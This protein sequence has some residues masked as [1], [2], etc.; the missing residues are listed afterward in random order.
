[1]K[2]LPSLQSHRFVLAFFIMILITGCNKGDVDAM[3]QNDNA[4]PPEDEIPIIPNTRVGIAIASAGVSGASL[5]VIGDASESQ[6]TRFADIW[7][8]TNNRLIQFEVDDLSVGGSDGFTGD[9]QVANPL[10]PRDILAQP[11]VVR[12]G[13]S[14]LLSVDWG[15]WEGDYFFKGIFNED[16]EQEYDNEIFPLTYVFTENSTSGSKITDLE[17]R[18]VSYTYEL[19]FGTVTYVN[20]TA[21]DTNEF[22]VQNEFI[23]GLNQTVIA[24]ALEIRFGSGTFGL[25][26]IVNFSL[27]TNFRGV[28]DIIRLQ[29][30]SETSRFSI[31][32]DPI[33]LEME[34]C[35]LCVYDLGFGF[36]GHA[37][38]ILVG[39]R[40]ESVIGSFEVSNELQSFYGTFILTRIES[41][42]GK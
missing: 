32:T 38:F 19:F 41:V 10:I 20:R 22:N 25:S 34:E 16:L 24:G 26:E 35:N 42:T 14:T 11:R 30:N 17:E 8:D 36:N 39:N 29:P 4:L 3:V 28:T 23:N 27:T 33:P 18:N 7:T 1:M 9:V 15:R 2:I 37:N 13:S 31:N 40:A 6:T 12:G 21:P 5:D